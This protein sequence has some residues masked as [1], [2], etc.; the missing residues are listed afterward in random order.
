MP[1]PR[2]YNSSKEALVDAVA[3]VRGRMSIC[4]AS[5]EFDVRKST[6]RDRVKNMH[7]KEPSRPCERD[8]VTEKT[9][10]ELVNVVSEWGYSLGLGGLEIKRM[11]KNFLDTKGGVS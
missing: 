10:A 4:Q 2:L 8:G 5:E 6:L 7:S 11:V 1:A 3:T 9:L